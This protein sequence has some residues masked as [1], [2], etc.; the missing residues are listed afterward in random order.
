M[1][2]GEDGGVAGAEE[3]DY[4]GQGSEGRGNRRGAIFR[5]LRQEERFVRRGGA[6]SAPGRFPQ[7]SRGWYDGTSRPELQK[8]IQRAYLRIQ[9]QVE[10][11]PAYREKGGM[12]TRAIFLLKQKRLG[13]YV[14]KVEAK[15]DMTVNVKMG[16]GMDESD[17]K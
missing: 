6:G 8:I 3:G 4:R 15:S 1:E 2:A 13:E 17:F 10:T 14:D 16:P 9:N 5:D 12:A 11:H 7:H